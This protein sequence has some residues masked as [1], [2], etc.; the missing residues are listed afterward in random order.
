MAYDSP[1]FLSGTSPTRLT[2]HPEPQ[3]QKPQASQE[4]T[5]DTSWGGDGFGFDDLIDLVNPLHHLPVIGTIYRQLSGDE[6]APEAQILGGAAFGGAIGLAAAG[7]NAIIAQ[8]TGDDLAGN[9]LALVSGDTT[10]SVAE[11]G[12]TIINTAEPI[13]LSSA[14]TSTAALP[15]LLPTRTPSISEMMG[16]DQNKGGPSKHDVILELFGNDVAGAHE[17]YQKAQLQ[18]HVMQVAKDME[19]IA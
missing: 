18:M 15:A 9:A 7:V 19:Q 11:E 6:I 1:N 5:Q 4:S 16:Q 17:Q 12:E 3:V 10:G 14:A 13:E 8:E 2:V